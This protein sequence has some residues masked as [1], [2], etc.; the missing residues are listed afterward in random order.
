MEYVFVLL[1]IAC[2][3]LVLLFFRGARVLNGDED[4]PATVIHPPRDSELRSE[5]DRQ[6]PL[7]IIR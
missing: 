6:L 4:A 3:A 2:V 1:Y 7:P 5:D